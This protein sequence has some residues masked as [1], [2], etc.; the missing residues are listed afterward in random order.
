MVKMDS[1]E[2]ETTSELKFQKDK[3]DEHATRKLVE[4]DKW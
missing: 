2:M 1:S 3:V 4:G